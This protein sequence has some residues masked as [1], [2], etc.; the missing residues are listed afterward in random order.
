MRGLVKWT[1]RVLLAKQALVGRLDLL[2]DLAAQNQDLQET[3]TNKNRIILKIHNER[4]Y[5]F[6]LWRQMGCEF[7]HTQDVLIEE[8]NHLRAK[9]G[10]KGEFY[11][12][13]VKQAFHDKFVD[14]PAH[15]VRGVDSEEPAVSCPPQVPEEAKSAGPGPE[16]GHG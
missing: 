6:A 12:Q 16:A 7:E 14:P 8:I 11:E 1:K 3:L 10:V 9:A 15:P 13:K 4:Q 2:P 5:W